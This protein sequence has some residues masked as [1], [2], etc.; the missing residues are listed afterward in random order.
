MTDFPNPV[1][2]PRRAALLA[3]VPAGATVVGGASDFSEQ[4]ADAVTAAAPGTPEGSPER[5]F[6]ER[7]GR[8]EDLSSF[9]DELRAYYDALVRRLRTQDGFDDYVRLAEARRARVRTMPISESPLLFATTDVPPGTR[10]MRTDG[11]VAEV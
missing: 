11:T 5:E 8:G 7:W 1:F 3:H 9:D 2:S 10:E 6:A 4:L